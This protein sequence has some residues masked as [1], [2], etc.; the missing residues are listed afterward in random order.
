[1]AAYLIHT[2]TLLGIYSIVSL[3]Y[4]I[5]VGYTGLLQLGQIGLFAIG[6]Y[7]SAIITAKGISF[8]AA[9]PLASLITACFGFLLALPSKKIKGD[10]YALVT[11]G[12]LF[13]VNAILLNWIDLTSGPFG[14]SGI[15]RPTGFTDP[16]SYLFLVA[17]ILFFVAWFVYRVVHSPF[18]KTL[19]AVRDDEVVAESLGKPTAKLKV[20]SLVVSAAIAGIAGALLAH[21]IQFINPQLFWLDNAVWILAALTVGG[22]ASFPG[23]LIGMGVLF[24]LLEPLRFLALPIGL[25]GPMRLMLFSL[26]LLLVVLFRPKGLLGRAQIEN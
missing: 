20:V 25:V 3:S 13:V 6:A 10:Y 1:M 18:G 12:F 4:A 24:I 23:A 2:L 17:I 22:L 7:A 9:L 26:L 19:E 8:W 11:L 14:I 21:F 16:I 5:P 15:K